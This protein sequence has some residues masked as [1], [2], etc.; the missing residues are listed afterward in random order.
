MNTNLLPGEGRGPG[1][2]AVKC[3]RL[4]PCKLLDPG[5]RRGTENA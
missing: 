3:L 1:G 4:K 2:E 5:L